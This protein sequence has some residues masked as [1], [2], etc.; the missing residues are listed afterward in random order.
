MPIRRL[1][2]LAVLVL[3]GAAS[4]AFGLDTKRCDG[5][6]LRVGDF[7]SKAESLCGRAY[8][9]DRWEELLYTDLDDRRS[10]RQRIDW[11]D[12]Y[13]DPGR[14]DQLFRVR[15]RQGQIVAIDTLTR[16]GG[17]AQPGDCTLATLERTQPVGEVVHRCGLPSQRI[18]LGAAVVDARE[19]IEAARDLRHE[20]WLYPTA[21]GRTLVLELRE[22]QLVGAGWR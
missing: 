14:G 6:I 15:S 18:D 2:L 5:R 22:G 16:R 13:F 9:I 1:S 17:P 19:R 21:D 11:S 12:R 10:L 7:E 3:L 8:Y 4:P 20:R